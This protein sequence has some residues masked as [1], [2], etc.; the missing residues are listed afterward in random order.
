MAKKPKS[1]KGALL[2]DGGA[3]QGSFFHRSVVLVCQHDS[4]GAFG[5]I[6]NRPAGTTVG[7]ALPGNLPERLKDQP[8]FEGGPV[9]TQAL[10]YL[11]SDQLLP[12]AN[13]LPNLSLGHAMEDLVELGS[14][15]SL[16]QRF[17]VFAGYAGWSPGQLDE[18]LKRDAWVVHPATLDL[19]FSPRPED[20]WRQILAKKGWKYRLL[21]EGP[22]D[23]SKN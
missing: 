14:S 10:S 15:G 7:E 8:L 2:L 23:P 9:Q 18:E 17:L 3:L 5:L 19:I 13:V 22:D 12:E 1:L 11:H 16:T 21:S 20:L 4:D 6:L